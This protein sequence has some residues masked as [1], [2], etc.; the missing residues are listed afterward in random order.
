MTAK[1]T[2]LATLALHAGYDPAANH[3]ARA[4]PIA[5]TT[6][7]V[8]EDA[9]H[10]AG[11]FALARP[12]HIYGRLSNPTTAVLEDRLAAYHGAAGALA[13]ASGASAVALTV[14]ALC[15]PGQHFISSPDLYGG[16]Q[17][18]FAHTFKRLGLK[19]VFADLNNP[20]ELR[21]AL[22]SNPRFIFTE[23]MA[24]PHGKI[25]DLTAIAQAAKE[26]GLPLV[27]DNT[28]TPP[29]LINP[30][31][32]G[33][34]ILVYSLTKMV[35]GHGVHLGGAI[36]E[37]G[38]FDWSAGGRFPEL[39]GPDASYQGL[40]FWEA[41]GRPGLAEGR[42]QALIV[43]IRAGLMRD[44]G[45]ALSPF[46][47]H[48]ILLGLETLPLRALKHA[49]NARLVAEFLAARPEVSWVSYPGL[50][51]SPEKPK[52]D[53]YL[54]HG[55][56]AVFGFG[57]KGG[58]EAG[59]R[60]IN[61]LKLASHLANILDARTLIIHPASTTHR[62]LTPEEQRTA[63]VSQDLVRISVGLEDIEDIKADLDQALVESQR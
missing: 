22:A 57:L 37:K 17:T 36:I 14:L 53:K 55:P 47:A 12:G 31:D 21:R 56:G 28:A 60:F 51:Q 16:T 50:P 58:L 40:N 59:R 42:G 27:V 13:T 61:S 20:G 8:F 26:A 3:L 46:G 35:G 43:K 33:A 4:V 9:D 25:A 41:F 54:P 48:E 44:I 2:A 52:A 32:F 11:L 63:G 49:Q 19:A 18:L 39:D 15:G 30:F 34:D 5:A 10:A 29:P 6:S 24:N 23:T 1:Q 45:P 38:D 7:Y 62:Q